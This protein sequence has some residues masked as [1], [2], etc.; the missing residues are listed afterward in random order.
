MRPLPTTVE[1]WSVAALPMHV[2]LEMVLSTLKGMKQVG[3]S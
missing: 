2:T 1:R 3:W